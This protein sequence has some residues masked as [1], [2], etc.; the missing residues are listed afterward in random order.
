MYTTLEGIA[1]VVGATDAVSAQLVVGHVLAGT[2]DA[3]IGR[4]G[5]SVITL[6]IRGAAPRQGFVDAIMAN[7]PVQRASVS[8]AALRIR[9]A[10]IRNRLMGAIMVDAQIDR[11]IVRV[12]T[13]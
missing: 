9:H 2:V 6:R 5:N 7:A 13:F 11:A 12:H 1:A 4:A 8:V 3:L 10:A